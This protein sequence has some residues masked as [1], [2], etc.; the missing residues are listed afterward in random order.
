MLQGATNLDSR[1]STAQWARIFFSEQQQRTFKLTDRM[2][3]VLMAVQWIAGIAA[4][5][6]ISPWSWTG[7][8]SQTH[9]HVWA[10]VFL[11][12][13]ISIFP[14]ILV[15]KRPGHASTRYV[16]A[17]AQMLMSALLI[18][19]TGGRIETHFHVFGSLAF[20]SFYRDW[21]VLVPATIVVAAD[22]LL[23]GI[24]WPESVYGVLA[25]SNWRWL[26]H[27]GWVLFEDTFL[28]LAILRSVDDMRNNAERMA[29]VRTLNEGLKGHATQLASANRELKDEITERKKTEELLRTAEEK[30]RSIFENSVEGIFQS[31]PGGQ[32]ISVN[33]TMARIYGYTSPEEM[34]AEQTDIEERHYVERARRAKFK[35]LLEKQNFVQGFESEVYRKDQTTFWASENVR[36]VLDDAGKVAYYEGTIEDISERRRAE[37]A[38]RE[39]EDRL[40]QAQKMEGIGQLAGGMAHDFNNILTAIC[41]YSDLTLR[42]LPSDHPL[43][44]NIEEIKKA[45]DRAASLTRQLLAFS[46]K[47]ILQP[48][49]INLNVVVPEMDK[50][51][52]RLIGEDLDLLTLLDP[53]LGSVKADPGQIEQVILNLAVNARDAMPKGGKLTIETANIYLGEEYAGKHNAVRPG[54]YVMLAVS[55]NGC[56]MDQDTQK[57][58]FDPFFTTKGVGKGTGLGLSTVYGIVKQSEGNIWVYSEL[59]RGTTFKIYLPRFDEVV[60]DQQVVFADTQLSGGGEVVLLVE[61]E[62]MVRQMA[63][64]ILEMNGYDVLEARHG[65]EALIISELYQDQ[66]DLMVTDVVMPQMGGPELAERL[67]KSRPETKVLFLSGYTDEAIVHHGVLDDTVNFLQ[68]P[69]TTDA[70]AQK[71][72]EVLS[73]EPVLSQ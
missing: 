2:F 57:R 68:K 16:I 64:Q 12:G 25:V 30:Y 71:V 26:E 13:A 11:G 41:G 44:R 23:R 55:D 60:D 50:M 1:E 56:G 24:F 73:M 7:R 47:Q 18:H 72:R 32:F 4:A 5:L 59:G 35:R 20:L 8:Y 39:S 38:L 27:A 36:V 40:R 29:E 65:K 33:P 67:A 61:D 53:E 48:K 69:F 43:R 31:T 21:R 51:L 37:E 17:V 14:I 58:I 10:A 3:A 42:R 54:H 34:I 9:I 46:R 45:G 22:H 63:R 15:L 49:V 66:I 6:W 28:Y 70:F 19:L 62:E 52:R